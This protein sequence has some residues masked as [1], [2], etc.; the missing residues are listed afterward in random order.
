M[1]CYKIAY[2]LSQELDYQMPELSNANAKRIFQIRLV[3]FEITST[4]HQNAYTYL[5]YISIDYYAILTLLYSV[6]SK[7]VNT[8]KRHKA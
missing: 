4:I 5:Q 1:A 2:N 3:V 7:T 6:F 8:F